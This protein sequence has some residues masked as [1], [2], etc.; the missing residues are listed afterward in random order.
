MMDNQEQERR[1]E[2]AYLKRVLAETDKQLEQA[3]EQLARREAE[4]V[5]VQRDV[6]EDGAR[7]GGSLSSA[8][9]FESLVELNQSMVALTNMAVTQDNLAKTIARLEALRPSPYFGRIDFLFHGEK[10]PEAFY[11]G[12][13]A[14]LDEDGVDNLIIDWRS[15]IASVFYRFLLGEAYYDAPAGRITGTVTRKRQYEINNSELAYFFDTDMTVS[16]G[17]L[18]ELLSQNASP[19]MRAIVETIQRDQDLIIRNLDADLLMIQGVAGSGKTAIALHRAAFLMYEGLA[20][21]LAATDILILSPNRTFSQYIAGVLPELGEDNVRTLT[22]DELAH[23]VL[24]D[25]HCEPQ[26]AF[27]ERAI[28]SSQKAFVNQCL[29]F[30]TSDAFRR[31]LDRFAMLIPERYLHYHDIRFGERLLISK[32][33][34]EAR[35]RDRHDLRLGTRLE[36]VESRVL[37]GLS[38]LSKNDRAAVQEQ[39]HQFTNLN[40]PA[41]YKALWKDERLFAE[42]DFDSASLQNLPAIRR[43]TLARLESGRIGFDDAICLLYLHLQLYGNRAWRQIRQIIIDEAQDY[44][45]LQFAIFAQ[46]FPNAKVT[47]L[48]DVNQSLTS[49][50]KADF[51]DHLQTLFAKERTVRYTL[52]KSFRCSSEILSFALRFLD[53]APNIEA[54]NRHG[55]TVGCHA[56]ATHAAYLDGLVEEIERCQHKGY[57]SICLITKTEAAAQALYGELRHRTTLHQARLEAENLQGTLIMPVAMTKGLEFDAVLLCDADSDTYRDDSDKHLLYITATRALHRLT[58]CAD[59]TLSPLIPSC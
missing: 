13:T 51:Y 4:M 21:K 37:D 49:L 10:Q 22:F 14:L 42:G 32:A 28:G 52:N 15:P 58:L 8:D 1:T 48:G 24:G 43:Q 5:S 26:S 41:L 19:Q 11:I 31:L 36:Q 3:R 29:A 59:G 2:E 40:L 44:T 33:E 46:L 38:G 50:P 18:K 53:T 27:L 47:I 45:P 17:I 56:F 34:L 16:D 9:G 57:A 7:S 39:L 23:D 54:F 30:K 6:F 25:L 20:N 12:R 55:D 35:V